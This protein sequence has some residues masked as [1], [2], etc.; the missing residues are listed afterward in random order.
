MRT[1][2]ICD[3]NQS[4]ALA[5]DDNT[6]NLTRVDLPS[7]SFAPFMKRTMDPLIDG[8]A[9]VLKTP[10]SYSSMLAY[11]TAR[12]RIHGWDLRMNVDA[13]NLNN[14]ATEGLISDVLIDPEETWMVY[15][16]SRGVYVLYDMR[17][18]VPLKSWKD[19][20]DGVIGKLAHFPQCC[21]TDN[22]KRSPSWDP[23]A[24]MISAFG[25]NSAA[26]WDMKNSQ[27]TSLFQGTQMTQELDLSTLQGPMDVANA[28]NAVDVSSITRPVNPVQLYEEEAKSAVQI[29]GVQNL[30]RAKWPQLSQKE[31]TPFINRAAADYTRYEDEVTNVLSSRWTS[32]APRT[33]LPGIRA[34]CTTPG[35][36]AAFLG[37]SDVQIRVWD[38]ERPQESYILGES[39]PPPGSGA[40]VDLQTTYEVSAK[41]PQQ[42][43]K[44]NLGYEAKARGATGSNA[45]NGPVAPSSAHGNSVT[46][47]AVLTSPDKFLISAGRDGVIKIW[48]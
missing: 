36:S 37:G 8:P 30:G 15:G 33:V 3:F 42:L 19:Q 16:T 40:R 25:S 12:G 22:Q 24:W 9:V 31:K 45:G 10:S 46:S 11:A 13:W 35:T 17:F 26:I 7:K 34:V 28:R 4:L 6:I 18:L 38:L 43:L 1:I 41:G 32:R 48:R 14:A 20:R 2:E 23:Q 29:K 21:R 5:A 47:L 44:E 39:R 27:T